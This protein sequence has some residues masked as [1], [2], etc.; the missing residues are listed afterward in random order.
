MSWNK[1]ICWINAGFNLGDTDAVYCG[2]SWE[3]SFPKKSRLVTKLTKI[4]NKN[5]TGKKLITILRAQLPVGWLLCKA[6][7]KIREIFRIQTEL[8][9]RERELKVP[10]THITGPLIPRRIVSVISSREERLTALQK[11]DELMLQLDKKRSDSNF[12]STPLV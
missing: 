1:S 2:N 3:K 4:F 5:V 9:R 10:E 7:E 11:Y 8:V 12:S 6:V